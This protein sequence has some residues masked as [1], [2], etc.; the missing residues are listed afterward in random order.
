MIMVILAVL[1]IFEMKKL[2]VKAQALFVNDGAEL[3]QAS[4]NELGYVELN[5]AVSENAN[6][7]AN[8]ERDSNFKTLKKQHIDEVSET[9]DE[10]SSVTL[11]DYSSQV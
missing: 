2:T 7:T 9:K 11:Q 1:S 8:I 5:N 6:S 3:G 10:N 4:Q